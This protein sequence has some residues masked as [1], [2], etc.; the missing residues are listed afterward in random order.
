MSNIWG[1]MPIDTISFM[2]LLVAI[3]GVTLG[4]LLHAEHVH[5]MRKHRH[6]EREE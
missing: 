6:R 1:R 4:W 2:A 3:M 5:R